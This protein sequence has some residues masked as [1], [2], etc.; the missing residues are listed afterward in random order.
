MNPPFYQTTVWP[1]VKP[2]N[3]EFVLNGTK[4]EPTFLQ[5][6]FRG[7]CSSPR[8]PVVQN[9]SVGVSFLMQVCPEPKVSI[10]LRMR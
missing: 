5:E 1:H 3:H 4:A 10:Y 6:T 7:T 8:V 2:T 9:L